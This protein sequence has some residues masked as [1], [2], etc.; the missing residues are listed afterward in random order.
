MHLKIL[1]TELHNPGDSN[2]RM[3]K[4][5]QR[6]TSYEI[7]FW[8]A[9]QL[10][11]TKEYRRF[12]WIWNAQNIRGLITLQSLSAPLE[13]NKSLQKRCSNQFWSQSAYSAAIM[14]WCQ[15]IFHLTGILISSL[16][17]VCAQGIKEWMIFSLHLQ[18]TCRE[19]K[20]TRYLFQD[21]WILISLSTSKDVG[22]SFS[23][24]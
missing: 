18:F 3:R 15:R 10:L 8:I 1:C 17:W 5:W 19:H 7:S 11:F 9:W 6:R 23:D 12:L 14:L 4:Y 13:L 16:H 24:L 2:E 22:K 20:E 21:E